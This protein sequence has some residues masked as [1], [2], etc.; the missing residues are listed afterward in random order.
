MF[1]RLNKRGQPA[2][3]YV[4]VIAVFV[5]ALIAMQV[6]FKRGIQG[7]VREASDDIG[8]QFSPGYTS[9]EFTTTLG[10]TSTETYTQTPGPTGEM[11]SETSL[12]GSTS[13]ARSGS[14]DVQDADHEYWPL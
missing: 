3:E 13:Q 10:G 12:T 11:M 5:A 7:R 2:L 4:M 9:N 1:I 8:N 14:E 6:Y